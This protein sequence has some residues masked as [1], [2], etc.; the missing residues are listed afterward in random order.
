VT[1]KKPEARPFNVGDAVKVNLHTGRIVDA[2][3]KAVIEQTDGARLQVDFGRDETALI[4][5]WQV[6][7]D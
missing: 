7:K 1:E 6:L 4:H 3:I 5:E 2:M